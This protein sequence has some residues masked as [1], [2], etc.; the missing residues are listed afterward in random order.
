VNI[1]VKLFRV[2]LCNVH[3]VCAVCLLG[4][5][6]ACATTPPEQDP[7]YQKLSEL[8]GRLLRIERVMT[9]QSLVDLAQRNETLQNEVRTLRGQVDELK[10]NADSQRDQQRELYADLERRLQAVEG[11]G[12]GAASAPKVN[13]GGLPVPEGNDRANYQAAFDRLKDSKYDEAVKAFKQFLASFPDSQLADNAQYWL[14]E[15]HYVMK[16][17]AQA[18]RDFRTVLDKYPES[19]KLPDALLKLGYCDYELKNWKEARASL[20]QVVQQFSDTTAARLASQRL[21]KMESEGH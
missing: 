13:A 20:T 12:G 3:T 11:G 8:D 4:V 2:F 6:T 16:D 21:A 17:F 15:S 19:R 18:Q 7:T 1:A 10:F 5:M 14:G 9:N